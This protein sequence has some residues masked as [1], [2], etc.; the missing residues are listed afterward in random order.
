M[1]KARQN[2]FKLNI[3]P[4]NPLEYG[5]SGSSGD[6]VAAWNALCAAAQSLPVTFP[7]SVNYYFSSKPNPISDFASFETPGFWRTY[8]FADYSM[9]ANDVFMSH[10][11][12]ANTANLSCAKKV[13]GNTGTGFLVRSDNTETNDFVQHRGVMVYGHDTGNTWKTGIH[14]DGKDRAGGFGCRDIWLDNSCA[15]DCTTDNL[16][17]ET[18]VN[19]F[20]NNGLFFDGDPTATTRVRVRGDSGEPSQRIY[21][22]NTRIAGA[23]TLEDYVNGFFFSGSIETALTVGANVQNS[24][25]LSAINP[26]SITNSSSSCTIITP[27]VARFAGDTSSGFTG[28]PAANY[29]AFTASSSKPGLRIQRFAGNYFSDFTHSTD[30][31]GEHCLIEVANNT[32]KATAARFYTNKSVFPGDLMPAVTETQDIGSP[33]FEWDNIYIQNVATV[34]DE[35]LKNIVGEIDGQQAIAFLQAL[36]PIWFSYK[37]TV[38]PAHTETRARQIEVEE[39]SIENDVI[40][41]DQDDS[42]K[43]IARIAPKETKR[44]VL[45]HEEYQV[46]VPKQIVPHGR[47][48]AGFSAQ[49]Y[50]QAMT[51]AGIEDFAAYAYSPDDDVY[52]LRLVENIGILVAANKTMLTQISALEARIAALENANAP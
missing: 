46:E 45:K 25:I 11:F 35:R 13:S 4:V 34:S 3:T 14:I 47:P 2:V 50:K 32:T 15:H 9:G 1:S 49:Q 43:M 12:G 22:S 5:V 52:H 36:S 38:I 28:A 19:V 44:T 16:L 10:G 26:S 8:L 20:V 17:I 23:L 18:G 29:H 7:L 40:G 31:D 30:A 27:T 42:G 51:A 33:T 6:N 21:I 41:F 37:P 24:L 39:V 48:H